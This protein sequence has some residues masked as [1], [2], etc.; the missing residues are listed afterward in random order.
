MRVTVI[1]SLYF[2]SIL[3]VHSQPVEQNKIVIDTV[4]FNFKLK[5]IA[6]ITSFVP[7][8]KSGI[9]SVPQKRINDDLKTYFQASSIKED[10]ATY[11]NRLL[12]QYQVDNLKEYFEKI[13]STTHWRGEFIVGNPFYYGDELEEFF[14]IEYVSSNI[15]NISITNQILPYG[16]Q[17]QSFF[18]SIFY[19]LRTGDKLNFND[20]LSVPKVVLNQN[21][22]ESGYWFEWDN[23]TQRIEKRPFGYYQEKYI[24]D[25]LNFGK[26]TC[27]DFYFSTV[28]NEIYLMIKL[29]CIHKYMMDF[30]MPLK[31]LKPYLE[32]FEFKNLYNLWGKNASSLIGQDYTKLG[33]EIVFE[34]YTIRYIGGELIPEES[35]DKSYGIAEYRS[36]E[37]RFLLFYKSLDTKKTITD[38]LEI[39]NKELQGNKLANYCFL[40]SGAG[41]KIIAIVK[42]TDPEPE[43]YTEILKAWKANRETGK[44]EKVNKRKIKKCGNEGYGL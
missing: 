34:D 11:V 15:L 37:K 43:F 14:K 13:E 17:P 38:I 28:D 41:S 30:G 9:N 27:Y 16:G 24:I 29:K 18:I 12:K 4:E 1:L 25:E 6:D 3:F 7:Q 22:Q 42:N 40:K 33:H 44:F 5:N 31:K 32:H 39:H 23:E 26:D 10:S 21:L 2:F 20:F 8:I 19:D 35:L 36:A